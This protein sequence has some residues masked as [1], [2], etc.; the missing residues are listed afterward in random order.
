MCILGGKRLTHEVK[1]SSR[2]VCCVLSKRSWKPDGSTSFSSRKAK[3][4]N[5]YQEGNWGR[6]LSTEQGGI[7]S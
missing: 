5:Y 3:L 4:M 2:F 7:D 6:S 1:G